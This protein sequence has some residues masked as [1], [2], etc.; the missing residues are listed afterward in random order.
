MQIKAKEMARQQLG[1][2]FDYNTEVQKFTDNSR[3]SAKDYND[4]LFNRDLDNASYWA[5]QS[6][7]IST[8]KERRDKENAVGDYVNNRYDLQW[9]REAAQRYADNDL[10]RQQ[11]LDADASRYRMNENAQNNAATLEQLRI[12]QEFNAQENAAQRASNLR[13][14]TANRAEQAANRA[15]QERMSSAELASRERTAMWQS[16]T[17]SI[18]GGNGYG[19]QYWG[20][21]V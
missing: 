5:Q 8:N 1:K 4:Y 14:N 11:A 13:E 17:G 20:G 15:S 10:G 12:Q 21:R 7:S 16:L 2:N 19:F 18:N 6:Q 3:N 9:S